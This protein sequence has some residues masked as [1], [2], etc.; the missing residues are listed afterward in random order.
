MIS[1]AYHTE[2]TL[3]NRLVTIYASTGGTGCVHVR[4]ADTYE[5]VKEVTGVD[6]EDAVELYE[7]LIN[8]YAK[9][10]NCEMPC[11]TR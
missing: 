7:K 8:L 6:T 10:E 5:V 1:I 3:C 9:Y 4:R 2:F 11:C